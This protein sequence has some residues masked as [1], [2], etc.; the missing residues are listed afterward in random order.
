MF[1]D[2]F[3]VTKSVICNYHY[4]KSYPSKPRALQLKLQNN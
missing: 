4:E 3:Y 1:C 2:L